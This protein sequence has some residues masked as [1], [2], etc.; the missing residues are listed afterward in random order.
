MICPT[1]TLVRMA[2][3]AVMVVK[4]PPVAQAMSFKATVG[5]GWG[6][7]AYVKIL[8]CEIIPLEELV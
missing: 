5:K 3:I 7:T 4:A 8:V 6:P 2:P 1:C